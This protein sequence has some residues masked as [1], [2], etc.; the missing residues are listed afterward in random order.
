V[1]GLGLTAQVLSRGRAGL[2]LPESKLGYLLGDGG[3]LV[4][5]GEVLAG[6]DVEA[7]EP[8]GHACFLAVYGQGHGWVVG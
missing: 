7:G 6:H 5:L 2:L 8:G 1:L 4:F 3:C